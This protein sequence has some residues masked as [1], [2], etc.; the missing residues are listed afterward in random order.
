MVGIDKEKELYDEITTLVGLGVLPCLSAFRALPNTLFEGQSSPSNEYLLKV[1]ETAT[2][3]LAQMEGE[4]KE[5]G[6]D[7]KDCRN[8]MLVL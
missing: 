6:P 8:N 2:E 5:L 1:Y 3:L 4:I 7:C